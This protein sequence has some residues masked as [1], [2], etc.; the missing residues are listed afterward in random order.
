M[1]LMKEIKQAKKEY[2]RLLALSQFS[3][4]VLTLDEVRVARDKLG[5]L[6][7]IAKEEGVK[8]NEIE[9]ASFAKRR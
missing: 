5:R 1:D 7:R 2:S 3:D 8:A 9:F 4:D 6:I